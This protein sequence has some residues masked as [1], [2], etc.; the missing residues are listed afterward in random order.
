MGV[1]EEMPRDSKIAI[2]ACS[3][4]YPICDFLENC[5]IEVIL[6]HPSKTR[7]IAEAK[8]KTDK[9]GNRFTAFLKDCP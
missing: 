1:I 6:S 7:I 4:W 5:G 2:V 9:E 3:Y 8:V